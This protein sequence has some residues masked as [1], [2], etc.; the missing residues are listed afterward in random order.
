MEIEVYRSMY[1][2]RKTHSWAHWLDLARWR[3]PLL[4][5]HANRIKCDAGRG[6]ECPVDLL[7]R[8]ALGLE[9]DQ[10][11][12]QRRLRVPEGEEQQGREQRRRH[13]LGTDVIGRTDDQRESERSDDLAE[14]ADAITEAHAAGAQPIGPDFG[15]VGADDRVAG[16]AEKALRHDEQE[17]YRY[18]TDIDVVPIAGERHR[19]RPAHA[20]EE[21]GIAPA[22]G[23]RHRRRHQPA[24]DAKDADPDHHIGGLVWRNLLDHDKERS[25]P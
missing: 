17:E 16:I 22:H 25:D 10:Q 21:P 6:V 14:I 18:R 2:I 4:R 5:R 20:D 15:D 9:A 1:F 11:E 19:D 12:H 24:N 7:D 8:P 23:V 3:G 13:D